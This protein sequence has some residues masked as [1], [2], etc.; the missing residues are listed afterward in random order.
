MSAVP[1]GQQPPQRVCPRCS[2][3]ARTVEARCPFCGSAYRRRGPWGGVALATILATAV[4]LGGVVLLLID[5]G[6]R[7]DRELE[8]Q[9]D[10]VQRDFDRDVR[11]LEDRIERELDE[12][13]GPG[14]AVP[15]TGG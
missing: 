5:F 1:T 14:G 2:T 4:I 10:V 11:G 3:L 6:D 15:P 13:L 7:L 8:D 12:R 9:V